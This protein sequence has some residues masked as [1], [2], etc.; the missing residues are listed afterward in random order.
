MIIA[1]ICT[2]PMRRD[3]FRQVLSRILDGQT[4]RVDQLHV[5]LNGYVEIPAD[6][7]ADARIQFH[8]EP[9][10]P[11][12]WVRYQPVRELADDGIFVTLDD[13]LIYPTDYVECGIA[14][15][16]NQPEKTSISFG[17]VFWDASVPTAKLDYHAHKRL[18]SYKEQLNV[19]RKVPVLM[20]GISFHYA[21]NLRNAIGMELPGFA[22]N[23]DL[24]VSYHLQRQGVKIVSAAKPQGWI[25]E[26]PNQSAG[27]A[28]W[29]TDR[30][31]RVETFKKLA[32][33]FGFQP[34]LED[35]L[36][37]LQQPSALII[38]AGEINLNDLEKIKRMLPELSLHTLEIVSGNISALTSRPLRDC[39]E[40]FVGVPTPDGRL[41][42][43]PGVRR[44]RQ[45]RVESQGWAQV[46]QYLSWLT[47]GVNIHKI[48]MLSAPSQP[49]WLFGKLQRWAANFP[50]KKIHLPEMQ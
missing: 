30:V 32:Q 41:E 5:W 49:A 4:Q 33:T 17:G 40:H 3:S 36:S 47:A 11:G 19:G 21:K 25:G 23:D 39:C 2:I 50:E 38:S 20:G 31:T 18:I 8:L 46:E 34:W 7:P 1:S 44:W 22:T 42:S 45:W 10:N 37:T 15:L 27:H 24:M 43:V 14:M 48:G 6:L 16:K 12:P 26:H 28:L 13:D 35:A 9:T 29:Q